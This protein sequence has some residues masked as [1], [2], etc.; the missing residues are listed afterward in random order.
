MSD[1]ILK[2]CGSDEV[3]FPCN[4]FVRSKH[5]E[6]YFLLLFFQTDFLYKKNNSFLK[7]EKH[8]YF[9]IPPHVPAE[10]GASNGPYATDWIHF[11]GEKC[12]EIIEKFNLP[13]SVP[14]Y[15]NDHSIILPYIK[16]IQSEVLLK[17][18]CYQEKISSLIIDMLIELGRKYEGKKNSDNH[19]FKN[20]IE[21]R[22]YMLSNLDKK[23][24]LIEIAKK[25]NYSLSRFCILYKKFFD[26]SPIE[27]LTRA[28]IEKAITLLS[29][30][31][32][33]VTEVAQL[34][35]FSSIHYFSRIFKEKTGLSPSKYMR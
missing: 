13:L 4:N 8:N 34:C 26:I 31:H 19:F 16:K 1:V 7:G 3:F 32:M 24:N 12:R 33:S 30:N 5:E 28:R 23:I 9:I 14:F 27:D 20:I 2:Y 11:K 35:G 17:G 18:T 29:H 6:S 21:A 25:A 22:S 15:I 10:H